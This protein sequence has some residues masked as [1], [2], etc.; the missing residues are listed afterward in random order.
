MTP[1]A[2]LAYHQQR[3]ALTRFQMSQNQ[4]IPELALVS[5]KMIKVCSAG[6]LSPISQLFKMM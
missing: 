6:V 5:N 2:V 1:S 3:E 4:G